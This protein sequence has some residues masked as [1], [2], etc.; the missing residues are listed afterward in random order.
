VDLIGPV[1]DLDRLAQGFSESH[2]TGPN[3]VLQEAR[4]A[5]PKPT[6]RDIVIRSLNG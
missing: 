5:A 1:S 4:Q 2:D 6:V 3:P